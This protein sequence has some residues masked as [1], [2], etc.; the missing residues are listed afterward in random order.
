MKNKIWVLLAIAAMVLMSCG[1]DSKDNSVTAD[2]KYKSTGGH[3]LSDGLINDEGK[4]GDTGCVGLKSYGTITARP[5]HKDIRR[6]GPLDAEGFTNENIQ[7]A[8]NII[9]GIYNPFTDDQKD[10]APINKDVK[11]FKDGI[12]STT[13]TGGLLKVLF[14]DPNIASFLD[15]MVKPDPVL[16]PDTNNDGNGHLGIG[17]NCIKDTGT[18]TGLQDYRTAAAKVKPDPYDE[19][20]IGYPGDYF[21]WP[22]YRVGAL[23][24]SNY[25]GTIL[26]DTV[27]NILAGYKLVVPTD[28]TR[29]NSNAC[30]LI[31][32]HVTYNAPGGNYTWTGTELG[33]QT[34]LS[35]GLVKNR[36]GSIAVG[37]DDPDDDLPIVTPIVQLQQALN[38]V[39]FMAGNKNAKQVIG[40]AMMAA[41]QI[42]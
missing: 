21:P 40:D 8:A 13:Y 14:S 4:C 1:T 2:C 19:M 29:L 38:R 39:I 25:P 33:I 27:N 31:E 11:I 22:I 17:E 20:A 5:E 7:N 37:T 9:M 28:K 18:C 26:D 6:V 15:D 10:R 32:V 23:T 34:G 12:E 35:E 3:G 36:F 24:E 41:T 16:C 42:P 30:G